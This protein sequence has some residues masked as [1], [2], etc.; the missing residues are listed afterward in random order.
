MDDEVLNAG[1]DGEGSLDVVE[2]ML[3]NW[4]DSYRRE[5][6][7]FNSLGAPLC[8]RR[9]RRL[10]VLPVCAVLTRRLCVTQHCTVK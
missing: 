6:W 7:S 4:L 10:R 1:G 2:M 3:E 9:S 8:A 5:Q